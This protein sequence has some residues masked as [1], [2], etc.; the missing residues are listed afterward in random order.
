MSRVIKFRLHCEHTGKVLAY[1]VFN[2]VLNDGYYWVDASLPEEARLC[3]TGNYF[4][5]DEPFSIPRRVQFT[6]LLDAN[7]VEV[8]EG[9][10]VSVPGLGNCEVR[11]SP[12]FGVVYAGSDGYEAPHSD[13]AAENDFPTIIGNIYQNP[14][15]LK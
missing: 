13:C 9:D 5:A 15:L 2:S 1:E 8:Y 7:G 11:I 4:R 10:I 14:E 3:N 6:G 12:Y